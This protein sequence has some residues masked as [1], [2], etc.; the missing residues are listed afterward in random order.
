MFII[1]LIPYAIT[2][3]D[4]EYDIRK[5]PDCTCREINKKEFLVPPLNERDYLAEQSY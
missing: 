3:V 1:K 4:L 2:V 5:K